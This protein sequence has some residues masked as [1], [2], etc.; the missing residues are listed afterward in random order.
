[1]ELCKFLNRVLEFLAWPLKPTKEEEE[2]S[3]SR[4]LSYLTT[5][6][7]DADCVVIRVVQQTMA[8]SR[9]SSSLAATAR[10][11]GNIPL[12]TCTAD[13]LPSIVVLQHC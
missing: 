11:L 4:Q 1:M 8:V 5:S 3:V 10:R 2:I 13:D 12:L 9:Q 7:R 6:D